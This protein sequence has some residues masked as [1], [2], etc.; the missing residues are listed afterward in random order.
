MAQKPNFEAAYP[1]S[2]VQQGIMFHAQSAP[3]TGTYVHQL[4]VGFEG[5]VDVAAFRKAW[6][7][8]LERHTI[9]RTGFAPV[10]GGEKLA[11]VVVRKV[12]LNLE[13]LDWRNIPR[14]RHE[15]MLDA[16]MEAD[17][18]HDF[19]YLKPPLLR[20]TLVRVAQNAY[21]LLCTNHHLILDGESAGL[22]SREFL[23]LYH[24]ERSG[25]ALQLP[26]PRPFSDYI[27]W[28]QSQDLTRA[29][30]YWRAKLNG[31]RSPLSFPERALR[32]EA[33]GQGYKRTDTW[34]S[35]ES[36]QKLQVFGRRLR[37]TQSTVV[38]GAWAILLSL[39][40]SERDVL[41]GVVVSGRPPELAGI[42]ST[43][44][45]FVNTLPLRTKV[46]PRAAIGQWLQELQ[47]NQVEMR[48]YTY[49]RP[50]DIQGYG[51]VGRGQPLFETVVNFIN[52]PGKTGPG[53][54][55]G[56]L[57]FS[58]GRSRESSHHP[59]TL[60]A[61]PGT[62]LQLGLSFDPGRFAPDA[63]N[64]MLDQTV[65]LIEAI[66]EHENRCVA[67]LPAIPA[68]EL[69]RELVDFNATH[70]TFPSGLRVFDPIDAR[71]LES[72]HNI[73]IRFGTTDLSYAGLS[74]RANQLAHHLRGLG[75][76]PESRVGLCIDRSIEMI[77]GLLGILKAGGVY[78]PLDP[79]HPA[80]R[81]V[82]MLSDSGA[83]VLVTQ[84]S[85][86]HATQSF[87]GR[88]VLLDSMADDLAS[89]SE[90]SPTV[91]IDPDNAAYVIYTS[92]STGQP[93]GV[94]ISHRGLTNHMSWMIE[95]VPIGRE[96][97]VLQKAP[98]TFDAS[99]WEFFAPLWTGARLVVAQPGE[100]RD[101]QSLIETIEREQITLVQFVP[102]LLS[103]FL[104]EP[105]IA[106]C[107]SLKRVFCGGEAL[108]PELKKRFFSRLQAELINLY[109]PT[110]TTIQ[111]VWARWQPGGE[112]GV[113][114]G[115]PISNV[116][117]YVVTGSGQPV[118]IGAI[119]ELWLGGPCLARGYLN[120]P[121][122]TAE[123]FVPD[124]FSGLPGE[125]LYRTG[126]L[127]RWTADG[128]LEFIGRRDYQL[129]I[130]GFRVELGEIEGQIAC[131]PAVRSVVVV[132]R[133]DEAG[134]QRLI[135]YIVASP[136]QIPNPSELKAALALR[137]PDYMLPA[138]FV[139][140]ENLPRTPSGKL[141]RNAL[142]EPS[143][144]LSSADAYV[145][146]RT[147]LE[148]SLASLWQE[149]L[150]VPRVGIHDDFFDL[151]GHSLTLIRL[152]SRLRQICTVQIRLQELMNLRTI[153]DLAQ[154]IL[155]KQM[156]GEEAKELARMVEDVR[157]L[158][159]EQARALYQKESE[160]E[161]KA[162]GGL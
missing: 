160:L 91:D 80:D 97:R 12:K 90:S 24:A 131:D 115:R 139:T 25:S 107:G 83:K 33:G 95:A 133:P 58:G 13:E 69:K 1:L 3:G 103:E 55:A 161:A 148:E 98:F 67:D 112:N 114:I 15:P 60:D 16:L 20:L 68:G 17:R 71:C 44:G 101:P 158:S 59:V 9:L 116:R 63:A 99:V 88:I 72:P 41:F 65:A 104:D 159:P 126:D 36:T 7:L 54:G 27:R 108:T 34:L 141:D 74:R 78:V 22:M 146:P 38:L 127:V 81:L 73:A 125:R 52:H 121:D 82:G 142:P 49:T 157:G 143:I 18:I 51:E 32:Q 113:P 40:T 26:N 5:A 137:L 43:L 30:A 102:S 136:G 132:A 28:L 117:A 89:E 109:G 110:E 122:I 86:A 56:A 42:Q 23:Q 62:R 119:G 14:Q 50:V 21:A 154:A 129:K 153:A 8:L 45:V 144:G 76:G 53:D 64:R 2:P 155:V 75:V 29:E 123:R 138:A 111:T 70:K 92:G 31:F 140:L 19:D 96:D 84:T 39:Y 130:R 93:K 85:V 120:R 118:P 149:L 61:I 134:I 79:S 46:S 152:A 100:H 47:A 106:R 124:G 147:P 156:E 151:G 48:E 11:Q 4:L 37:I 135:A 57:Q 77:V 35:S 87:T 105:E 162:G 66:L 10:A 145:E 94:V 128:N 6:E 150:G